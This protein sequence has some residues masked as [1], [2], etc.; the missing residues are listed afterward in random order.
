MRRL[1]FVLS[2]LLMTTKLL[3]RGVSVVNQKIADSRIR[4]VCG[5]GA[6]G[7]ARVSTDVWCRCRLVLTVGAD[8]GDVG[9]AVSLVWRKIHCIL[10]P[11]VCCRL[12]CLLSS[13][14]VWRG[15]SSATT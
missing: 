8:G 5:F 11:G 2:L 13:W 14:F 12:L 6:R 4:S 7:L 10:Y 15:G 1:L 3:E 9:V